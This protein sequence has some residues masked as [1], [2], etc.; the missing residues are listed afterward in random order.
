VIDRARHLRQILVAGIGERGQELL[1]GAEAEVEG[2]GLSHE[3]AARYAR[4]AGFAR[5]AP[6]T[7]DEAALA[8]PFVRA[9][10]ARAVLAGSRAALAAIRRA[11]G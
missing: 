10:A 3:V 11:I 8:P 6:G 2:T 5:L 9:P 7:I 4:G 1:A